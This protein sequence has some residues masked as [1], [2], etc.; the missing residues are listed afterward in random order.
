MDHRVFGLSR[1]LMTSTAA[2]KYYHWSSGWL[3]WVFLEF[4][5]LVLLSESNLK[6][7]YHSHSRYSM[8]RLGNNQDVQRHQKILNYRHICDAQVFR[9]ATLTILKSHWILN[10][11]TLMAQDLVLGMPVLM[12]YK[13]LS[14]LVTVSSQPLQ[15]GRRTL[16]DKHFALHRIVVVLVLMRT[17]YLLGVRNWSTEIVSSFRGLHGCACTMGILPERSH[18]PFLKSPGILIVY[19]VLTFTSIWCITEFWKHN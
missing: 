12:S 6:Y 7:M 13:P 15:R 19:E 8:L 2:Q 14:V 1:S 9:H 10:P 3:C 11:R 18:G 4:F 16:I 17:Y 5:A